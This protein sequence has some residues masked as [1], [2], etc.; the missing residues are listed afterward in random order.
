MKK[1]TIIFLALALSFCAFSQKRTKSL[2][3]WHL[4]KDAPT[5]LN[6]VKLN[7]GTTIFS[8]YPEISA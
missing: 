1:T 5:K 3:G 8:L 4:Q 7:L 6:E 2:F